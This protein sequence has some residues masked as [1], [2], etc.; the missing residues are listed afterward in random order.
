MGHQAHEGCGSGLR[1]LY[2]EKPLAKAQSVES[3]TRQDMTK[4]YA[5]K[6]H[7][8]RS[9]Q[10]ICSNAA[11]KCPFNP[12]STVVFP[13]KI[14]RLLPLPRG[15]QCFVMAFGAQRECAP[16]IALF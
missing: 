12:S 7:I 6:S 1:A 16:W 3:E 10:S 14:L 15:N 8:A 13:V 2:P 4:A 9:P 5:L 11:R